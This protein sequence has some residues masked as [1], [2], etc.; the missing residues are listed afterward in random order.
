MKP[1][2]ELDRITKIADG[3]AVLS[4]ISLALEPGSFHVLLGRTGAGKTSLLRLMAGL[5]RPSAG[6]VLAAGADV[7]GAPV[8]QRNVAF[9]Y[10]QFINYPSFTVYENIASPLRQRGLD[11]KEIDRRVRDT[12]KALRLSDLLERLPVELSGGQQ[13]RTAMARALVKDADLLLLDEPFAGVDAATE[14]A[15]VRVLKSLR[16]EGKSVV[17][18]HHDLGTVAEYFDRVLLLNR[19]VLAE[20]PS[21]VVL[22]TRNLQAT[23][24]G[25]LSAG[26]LAGVA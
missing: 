13:Q 8:R 2:I 23:Y 12:A 25:R 11:A 14:A 26:Q 18:V 7:T 15:I 21:A 16:N 3:H 17:C 22:T 24:G 4:D 9:V 1:G 10:Q 6:K 20:G 5:D 19:R